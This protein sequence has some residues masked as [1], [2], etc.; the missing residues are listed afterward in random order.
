[1]CIFVLDGEKYGSQAGFT[2]KI[3][4]IQEQ[5]SYF[6][7]IVLMRGEGLSGHFYTTLPHL[8][9]LFKLKKGKARK[10][11]VSRC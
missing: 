4:V 8:L 11:G 7:T 10:R 2:D 9:N 5:R 3:K 1:M 6:C